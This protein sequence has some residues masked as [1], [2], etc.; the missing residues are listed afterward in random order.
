MSYLSDKIAKQNRIIG[1]GISTK[2]FNIPTGKIDTNTGIDRIYQSISA[3]LK[4]TPGERFFLPEFGSD[5]H[6]LLFEPNDYILEDL[7]KLYI[8]DALGKWEPR[9]DVT[10]IITKIDGN[11]IS[12]N[13]LFDLSNSNLNSNYVFEFNRYPDLEGGNFK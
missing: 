11:T 13:I 8:K 2:V 5:I 6:K 9:I 10:N 1:S 3:I 12:A 7:L 4:T